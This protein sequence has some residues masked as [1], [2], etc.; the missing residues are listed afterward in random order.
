MNSL[1]LKYPL[2]IDHMHFQGRWLLRIQM[3]L[4]L[5]HKCSY[6][7]ASLGHQHHLLHHFQLLEG[8]LTTC[9]LL[10]FSTHDCGQPVLLVKSLHRAEWLT[11]ASTASF[12]LPRL[13]ISKL[14]RKSSSIIISFSPNRLSLASS[15]KTGFEGVLTGHRNLIPYYYSSF[16]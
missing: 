9:F 15:L 6:E 16:L 5:L 3:S 8:F 14:W 7:V 11:Y 2:P 13:T 12:L 1:V 4:Y 10:P